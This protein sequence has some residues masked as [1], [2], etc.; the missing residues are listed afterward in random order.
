MWRGPADF[1]LRWKYSQFANFQAIFFLFPGECLTPL[2]ITCE[3]EMCGRK[4][5]PPPNAINLPNGFLYFR[6][7]S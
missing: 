7:M 4:G 6:F 3:W 2:P 1:G 5:P